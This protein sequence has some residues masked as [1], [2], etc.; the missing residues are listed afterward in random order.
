M[1]ISIASGALRFV[2]YH[3]EQCKTTQQHQQQKTEPDRAHVSTYSQNNSHTQEVHVLRT[4]Q[5]ANRRV[6]GSF[7]IGLCATTTTTPVR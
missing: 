5:I 4:L 7:R 3:A 2:D 1:H 6:S